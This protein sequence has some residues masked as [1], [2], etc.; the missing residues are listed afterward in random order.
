MTQSEPERIRAVLSVMN[1]SKVARDTNVP[2]DSLYRFVRGDTK[3]ID[4]TMLLNISEYIDNLMDKKN[5]TA[6]TND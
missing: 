3:R 5:A 6:N 1:L 4:F 2:Y